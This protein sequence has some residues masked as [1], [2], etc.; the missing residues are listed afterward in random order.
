M[1]NVCVCQLSDIGKVLSRELGHI[2][3]I[4]CFYHKVF[5]TLLFEIIIICAVLLAFV[6]LWIQH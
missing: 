3:I 6:N 1:C 4:N 2:P 5:F